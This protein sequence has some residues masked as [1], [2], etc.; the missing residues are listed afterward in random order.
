MM[1]PL[2]SRRVV[3]LA[4]NTLVVIILAVVMLGAGLFLFVSLFGAITQ[5]VAA[6]G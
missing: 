5:Q 2:W 1:K 6:P 4:I 3:E